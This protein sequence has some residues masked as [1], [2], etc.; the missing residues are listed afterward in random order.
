MK[1]NLTS[2]YPDYFFSFYN[3]KI[4]DGKYQ[5]GVNDHNLS[6]GVESIVEFINNSKVDN[7]ILSVRGK[8]EPFMLPFPSLEDIEYIKSNSKKNILVFN[9]EPWP[10]PIPDFETDN[11]A[12]VIKFGYDE[13]CEIDKEIAAED[14]WHTGEE[15]PK[16][17]SELNILLNKNNVITL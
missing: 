17:D 14:I 7:T 13:E 16:Q 11:N 15:L 9:Q 1:L 12:I 4:K 5:L 10:D 3:L 8:R 2:K 6:I